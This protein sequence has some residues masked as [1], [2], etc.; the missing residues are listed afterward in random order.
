M[1]LALKSSPLSN[2][3][4]SA[5]TSRAGEIEARYRAL[6]PR[7]AEL[8]A[9]AGTV[10]PGGF[11]RDAVMRSPYAPFIVEGAGATLVDVDGRQLTDMWFNATSL[12][13]GHAHPKV[14]AA[15]ERQLKRGT[16]YFAP[17]EH[18]LGLA[19]ILIERVPSA[20]RIRF[21]N[22]GS[23]AVM[24]ALRFARAARGRPTV[25]KF[26]GSYHGSYDDVSWSVSPALAHVGDVGAPTPAADTA[27]LAGTDGRV[28]VLPF[29]NGEVL[30]RTVTAR[31]EE[32][33][34]LIVEPMANRMGLLL[35]DT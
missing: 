6:T 35:P 3:F 33:A 12:P 15:A 8:F 24:M 27:G 22:S 26:E 32:I 9:R 1:T 30:R 34:A 16:A 2:D 11:T 4:Y 19:E 31:H 21:A 10:F 7:S 13:L 25:V 20:E 5:L 18:E 23:D 28:I 17:T 14:M 29:N